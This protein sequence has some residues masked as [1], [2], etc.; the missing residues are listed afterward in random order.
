MWFSFLCQDLNLLDNNLTTAR[1]MEFMTA[2]RLDPTNLT[3]CLDEEVLMCLHQ[4]F[5]L[6]S[7]PSLLY[8]LLCVT[9]CGVDYIPGVF[10]STIQMC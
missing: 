1:L 2:E 3:S 10:R 8:Y 5:A 4:L 7:Y 9:Y 6:L